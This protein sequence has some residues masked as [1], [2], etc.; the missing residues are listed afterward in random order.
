VG[1]LGSN[2]A[3]VLFMLSIKSWM[4]EDFKFIILYSICYVTVQPH[5]V[6]KLQILIYIFNI[7]LEVGSMNECSQSLPITL[8]LYVWLEL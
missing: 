4:D 2:E 1:D 8:Y 7:K 6:S 5:R 3:T